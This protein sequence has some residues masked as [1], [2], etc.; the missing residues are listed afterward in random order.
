VELAEGDAG[1]SK[2]YKKG[3]C[4]RIFPYRFTLLNQS[5]KDTL[6]DWWQKIKGRGH[7]FL[8][9]P[10]DQFFPVGIQQ[11]MYCGTYMGQ[12]TC[13][14]WLFGSGFTDPYPESFSVYKGPWAFI[15]NG[16]YRK[17]ARKIITGGWHTPP[18][19]YAEVFPVFSGRII[20]W[21]TFII[22]YPVT[23]DQARFEATPRFP[24]FWDVELIFKEKLVDVV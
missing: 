3:I 13:N 22:G 24:N 8:L 15:L 21:T 17:E 7:W 1:Y 6:W 2:V 12:N 23:L 5:Q 19:P 9:Q 14:K 16:N 18:E 20:S 10:Q 4:R 11:Q